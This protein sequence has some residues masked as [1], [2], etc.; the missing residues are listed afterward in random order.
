MIDLYTWNTPNGRKVSIALEEMGLPY[1]IFPVNLGSGEQ[2]G[3]DF[4][5]ISPNGKIPAIVDRD[6][7]GRTLMESGAILLYLAEKTG[8]LMPTDVEGRWRTIEWLMWEM[9]G[10]GPMLSQHIHFTHYNPDAS[11][12]ARERYAAE[13]LRLYGV[14]ESRLD[15]RDYV[16]GDYSIADIAIWPWVAGFPMHQI[17]F[18]T[19]PN[20]RRWYQA[21]ANRRAVQRGWR[22]PS[23]DRA[24]P[25]PKS[26]E[27]KRPHE[28]GDLQTDR[29]VRP[30]G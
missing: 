29:Q 20:V 8:L 18:E 30:T 26:Q 1:R 17:D 28:S 27:R 15:S 16:V 25:F 24:I 4:V 6:A 11:T 22:I 21:I 5:R 2:K 7:R 14:L 12:Y 9:G 13:A 19:F 10:A 3:R 23:N